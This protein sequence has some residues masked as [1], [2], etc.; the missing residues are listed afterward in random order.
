MQVLL[1][2][3]VLCL[4]ATVDYPYI[5]VSI[6]IVYGS[7][8]PLSILL[9]SPKGYL[10]QL[11]GWSPTGGGSGL[12]YLT[13]QSWLFFTYLALL[14][15]YKPMLRR[16]AVLENPIEYYMFLFLIVRQQLS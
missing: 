7:S 11:R 4:R 3:S 1:G 8:P 5:G 16:E 10:Q 2:R 6:H 14:P 12:F 9:P 15:F 13:V